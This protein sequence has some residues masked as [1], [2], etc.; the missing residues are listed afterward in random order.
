M[1]VY[2][3]DIIR[4]EQAEMNLGVKYILLEKRKHLELNVP[5]DILKVDFLVLQVLLLPKQKD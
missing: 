4:N 2:Y 1:D 3:C 5:E